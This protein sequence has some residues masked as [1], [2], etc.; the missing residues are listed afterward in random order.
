MLYFISWGFAVV[1]ILKKWNWLYFLNL[2]EQFDEISLV[3]WY[4]QDLGQGIAKYHCPFI[5]R[6]FADVQ[7]VKT[8]KLPII[9]EPL[10]IFG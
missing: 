3:H 1:Q 6:G 7:T 5:G 8:W 2:M 9:L 10:G 4:W